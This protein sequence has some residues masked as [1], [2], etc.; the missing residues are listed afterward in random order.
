MIS[1]LPICELPLCSFS[2]IGRAHLSSS[3]RSHLDWVVDWKDQI[4]SGSVQHS[5][6]ALKPT[7]VAVFD[8]SY[9]DIQRVSTASGTELEFDLSPRHKVMGSKLSVKLPHELKEGETIELIIK[10]ATTSECTALG[11]LKAEQTASGLYPFLFSQ[12][13][14]SVGLPS[15][16]SWRSRR[17]SLARRSSTHL[18]ALADPP[19]PPLYRAGNPLPLPSPRARYPRRQSN[20]HLDRHLP[21]PHS[22][23]RARH[24]PLARRND[25]Q[26]LSRHQRPESLHLGTEGSYPLLPHRDRRWGVGVCL[27]GRED[28]GV[29]PTFGAQGGDVGV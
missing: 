24:L 3:H 14:V 20:L 16:Y 7:S 2:A 26:R 4:I 17:L 22:H 9:L 19:S 27:A 11:W 28:R 25:L 8:S 15:T 5:M 23:V 6:K 1:S 29:G 12:C 13:Q 18:S 21:A 10:Y